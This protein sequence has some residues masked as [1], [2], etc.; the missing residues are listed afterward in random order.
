MEQRRQQK[1]RK[2][3]EQESRGVVT[4]L[5]LKGLSEHFRRTANRH[6]FR[7]AFKLRKKRLNAQFKSRLVKGRI[8]LYMR[9]L[10]L[11]RILCMWEKHGAF[12]K[13]GRKNT[14]AKLD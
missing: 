10:V 3:E 9:F 14:W 5:Y 4:I 2:Q 1:T 12:Y 13:Q 11:A 7:V 6:S 8:A